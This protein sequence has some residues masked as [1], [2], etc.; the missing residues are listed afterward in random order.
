MKRFKEDAATKK[1]ERQEIVEIAG[2]RKQDVGSE[3][4]DEPGEGARVSELASPKAPP[5]KFNAPKDAERCTPVETLDEY[6]VQMSEEK[7][8]KQPGEIFFDLSQEYY[9]KRFNKRNYAQIT[10]DSYIQS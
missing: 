1:N 6:I 2:G 8:D 3:S 5:S 10:V 9:N 4:E 7:R